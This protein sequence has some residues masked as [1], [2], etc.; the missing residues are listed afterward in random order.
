MGIEETTRRLNDLKERASLVSG[1]ERIDKL[2]EQGYL[3][4]EE[5]VPLLVDPGTFVEFNALA[6][7]QPTEF[8]P[9][10]PCTEK[11][12]AALE[13]HFGLLNKPIE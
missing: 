7:P 4:A 2:K 10:P 8:G 3:T 13:E 6:G 1:E 11:A 9:N 5:R 12:I